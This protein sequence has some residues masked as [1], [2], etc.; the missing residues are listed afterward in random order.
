M[1]E[2][3]KRET[4]SIKIKP[5]LWKRLKIAAIKKDKQISEFIEDLIEKALKK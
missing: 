3:V 2:K 1:V 4:R 5:G